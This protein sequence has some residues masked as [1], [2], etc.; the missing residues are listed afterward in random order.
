V[1][2]PGP[3]TA[4]PGEPGLLESAIGY[5]LATVAA[6]TPELLPRATPCR[7]WDLRML[8]SHCAESLTALHEAVAAGRMS[9]LASTADNGD[10]Y[11]AADHACDDDR[12]MRC[13]TTADAG[14]TDHGPVDHGVADHGA[15]DLGPADRSPADPV[16][17]VAD[18]AGRLLHAWA[19]PRGRPVIAIADR[20]VTLHILADLGALELAVHGWDISRAAGRCAPIPPALAS[21]LLEIAPRLVP[22]A[23][24][25]PLFAAPVATAATA[26]PSDRLA[27]FLGRRP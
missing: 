19:A 7:G 16:R 4:Q 22:V 5:A 24:R 8:L 11:G 23:G 18:R 20:Y 27:A 17:D 9:L 26:C 13:G 2:A 3:S 12:G 21:D 14:P 1:T 6:V 10:G 25:E 15:A